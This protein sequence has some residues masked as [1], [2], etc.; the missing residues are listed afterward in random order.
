VA[1]VTEHIGKLLREHDCVIV[2]GLGG[3]V[4]NYQPAKVHPTSYIFNT[5]SKSIAFNV[6]LRNND[7]LLLNAIVE[8]EQVSVQTAENELRLFVAQIRDALQEHK[9]VKLPGIG[10]LTVDA[11]DHILFIPDNSK[12]YL[13]ESYG[14]YSFV[15]PPVI[16]EAQKEIPHTQPRLRKERKQRTFSDVFLPA[17]AVLLLLLITVQ[18]YIQ[19]TIEGYNYAEIF[20]LDKFFSND[21]LILDR[22]KPMETELNSSLLAARK[23]DTVSALPLLPDI[24]QPD[25]AQENSD[26]TPAVQETKGY[27]LIAGALLSVEDAM[28]E[29]D[30]LRNKNYTGFVL[31]KNG[32]QMVAIGIP[33]SVSPATFRELFIEDTGIG[34]AWVLRNK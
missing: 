6:N 33:D 24:I 31:Y 18:I 12:N 20:G 26:I 5:P 2:P 27:L 25:A 8:Q 7:G 21:E 10:R 32:Y 9:P 3:F 19:S 14:L 34:D 29:V 30:K 17:A 1:R 4:G 23:V 22:Y 28:R 15:A 13:P 16:R 11:E